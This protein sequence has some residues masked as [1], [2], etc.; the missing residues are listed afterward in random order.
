MVQGINSFYDYANHLWHVGAIA[1]AGGYWHREHDDHVHPERTREIGIMKAI[2][3][4]NNN[5]LTIFHAG[6]WY[7]LC[8][9]VG[10]NWLD[11]QRVINVF[12][13]SYLASQASSN[14][15]MSSAPIA[16]STPFWPRFSPLCLPRWLACSPGFILR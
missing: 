2:G 9:R 1:S 5:I 14:G 12:A 11:Y 8:R 10:R 16:T 7:W 6:G 13:S 4:T 15:Y 3:A